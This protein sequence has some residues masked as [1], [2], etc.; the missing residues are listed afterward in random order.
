MEEF[1][2]EKNAGTLLQKKAVASFSLPFKIFEL[3]LI[4]IT[5]PAVLSSLFTI[6]IK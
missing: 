4:F 3:H 6:L 2:A 1:G 5:L